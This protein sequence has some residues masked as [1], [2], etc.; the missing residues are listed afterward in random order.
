MFKQL[1][2]LQY[3]MDFFFKCPT[4]FYNQPKNLNDAPSSK[5]GTSLL[6]CLY[7]IHYVLCRVRVQQKL[8][9]GVQLQDGGGD[10]LRN[11]SA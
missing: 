6:C 8:A 4:S 1:K 11:R 3:K 10:I 5:P 2:Y 7:Q 9:V